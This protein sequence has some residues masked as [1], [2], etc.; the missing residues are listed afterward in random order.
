MKEKDLIPV[1]QDNKR[2]AEEIIKAKEEVSEI[3]KQKIIYDILKKV[4]VVSV[5]VNFFK[6]IASCCNL[7]SLVFILASSLFG[8]LQTMCLN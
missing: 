1:L 3:E 8:T 4:A 7:C 5:F 2:L 6:K